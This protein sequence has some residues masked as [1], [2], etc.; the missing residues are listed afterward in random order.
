MKLEDF[1]TT[2]HNRSPNL[3]FLLGAGASASSKIPT[4][5]DM[6]WDFKRTIYCANNRLSIRNIPDISNLS[7]R[8]KIQQYFDSLKSFPLEGASEEYEAY[9]E[10]L[11]RTEADRRKYID[12]MT[13]S[14]VPSYGHVAL[15]TL[16]ALKKVR[17]VWTTNFDR[18]IE[19]ASSQIFETGSRLVIST[20]DTPTLAF[21]AIQEERWPL[22]VKL[23]GD[24]QSRKLKNTTPELQN[25]D[26]KLRET[27]TNIC[28]RFGLIVMGYSGRDQS[29]MDCLNSSLVSKE[30]FPHGIFWIHRSGTKISNNVNAFISRAKELGI[31]AH[32]VQAETFDEVIADLINL[33]K[34]IP[35]ALATK[36][37][38]HAPRVSNAPLRLHGHTYPLV[39]LNG[40]PLL[41]SPI[42]C[43]RLV[44]KIGGYKE[45]REA[46]KVSNANIIAGRRK[47]GIIAFG[48]DEEIK[49]AF[50]PYQISDFDLH[51][52]EAS[53]LTTESAELGLMYEAILKALSRTLPL[54]AK[55]RRGKYQL[56]LDENKLNKIQVENLKKVLGQ[57]SGTVP[58]TSIKWIQSLKIKLE[59]RM[60]RLWL[61]LE[62]AFWAETTKQTS[63][64]HSY[65]VSDF[66]REKGVSRYNS[67]WSSVLDCWINFIFSFSPDGLFYA[68]DETSGANAKFKIG[69][70]TAFALAERGEK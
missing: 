33:L 2:F 68:F 9:F 52:I 37:N 51:S 12:G 14:A 60:D 32:F 43:R 40:L 59:Y 8:T 56:I 10:H 6:I 4:A 39:R 48:P 61:I 21:E 31:D 19:D 55:K 15:A 35:V 3:M 13:S 67:N 53:R 69:K 11:H 25:Q 46:I 29:V 54:Q 7:I 24:L 41:D 58:G 20:L 17:I 16:L 49:R 42:T 36:I 65:V 50:N 44:C 26:A 18:I 30:S 28:Q 66:F 38:A 62:P 27:L 5:G 63:N 45:I 1:V 64:K 47:I 23:H 70:R 57:L 22:F 34:E